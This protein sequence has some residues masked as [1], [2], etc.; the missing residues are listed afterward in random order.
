V[1]PSRRPGTGRRPS[2]IARARR[3][4]RPPRRLKPTR[5]GW[6]FFAITFGVGFAAFNTGNNLLY[7]VFSL[8]LAF[9]VLSGVLSESALRGIRIKRRLPRELFV[10]RGAVVELGITNDQ[11]R[12]PAFAIV[13]E[14]RVV[15]GEAP[16][17]PGGRVFALRIGAGET[18]SRAYHLAPTRRG[19]IAFIGFVVYTRFPFGLFSKSLELDAPARSLVYPAIETVALPPQFGRARDSGEAVSGGGGTGAEVTGLREYVRGDATRR[20]HWRASLR[21]SVLLVREVESESDA[22]VE[23]RLRTRGA[24]PGDAFEQSVSAAASEALAHLAARARVSL[25]T[26][27][28]LVPAAAGSAQRARILALLARVQATPAEAA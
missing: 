26:D 9:L 2:L 21:R 1:D 15:E 12:V 10:G 16:P 25:R 13:V 24:V 18:E 14:D 4:L 5:A 17:R 27:E 8:M 19:E 6:S 7:L 20:L 22:E 11:A 28:A 23:V 3:W